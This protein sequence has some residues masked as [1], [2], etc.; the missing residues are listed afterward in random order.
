[1]SLDK[2]SCS[3]FRATL[4][5]PVNGRISSEKTFVDGSITV[6]SAE[7]KLSGKISNC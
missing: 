2:S 4:L 7:V 5:A 3:C 6:I 1:M